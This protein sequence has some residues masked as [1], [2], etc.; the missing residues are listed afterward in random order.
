MRVLPERRIRCV[1]EFRQRLAE[2]KD[3]M[4]DGV[5]RPIQRPQSPKRQGQYYSGKKKSHR[6]KN[7]VMTDARRRVLVLTPSKPGRRHAIGGMKR[8]APMHQVLRNKLG[9]F[10]DCAAIVSAVVLRPPLGLDR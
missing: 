6:R 4:L 1:A 7:L 3:V 9:H 5:E 2:V 8:Y 10:D